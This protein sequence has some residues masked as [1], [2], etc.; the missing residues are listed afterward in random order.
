MI[1]F[2]AAARDVE[3]CIDSPSPVQNKEFFFWILCWYSLLVQYQWSSWINYPSQDYL[4]RFSELLIRD[5]TEFKENFLRTSE[6]NFSKCFEKKTCVILG[7][8]ASMILKWFLLLFLKSYHQFSRTENLRNFVDKYCIIPWRFF[9]KKFLKL[10]QRKL[11]EPR[12][13]FLWAILLSLYDNVLNKFFW[14]K[15]RLGEIYKR[16]KIFVQNCCVSFLCFNVFLN[17]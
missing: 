1:W 13:K 6:R 10:S 3:P 16:K 9:L 5:S 11:L 4:Q 12:E 15:D 14:K 7:K 2:K 17:F 8:L